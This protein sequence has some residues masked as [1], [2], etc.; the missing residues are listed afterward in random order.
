MSRLT[1][2]ELEVLKWVADGKTTREIA[3]ILNRSHHTIEKHRASI[4][5]K[6]GIHTVAELATFYKCHYCKNEP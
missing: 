1:P 6:L 4:T 3:S 2:R 5:A